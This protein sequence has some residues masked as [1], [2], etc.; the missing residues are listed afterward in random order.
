MVNCASVWRDWIVGNWKMEHTPTPYKSSILC[1]RG[2]T[3]MG[4]WNHG[5]FSE[6]EMGSCNTFHYGLPTLWGEPK[7][8]GATNFVK[9]WRKEKNY[10]TCLP[11]QNNKFMPILPCQY[12]VIDSKNPC[13]N[14]FE[15]VGLKSWIKR[16]FIKIRV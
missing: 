14:N 9:F 7:S 1:A 4:K 13:H 2:R 15:I 8:E 12:I 11:C 6:V 3:R 16:K 5:W 10:A